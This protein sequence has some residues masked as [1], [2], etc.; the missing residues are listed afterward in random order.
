MWPCDDDQQVTFAV[1]VFTTSGIRWPPYLQMAN[2]LIA[3]FTCCTTGIAARRKQAPS[4]S[5][6]CTGDIARAASRY[7]FATVAFS[8]AYND[9]S[10]VINSSTPGTLNT[11]EMSSRGSQS[12]APVA[13]RGWS[14]APHSRCRTAAVVNSA[15]NAER[16]SSLSARHL[17]SASDNRSAP[18]QMRRAPLLAP[19]RSLPSWML[20]RHR[21]NYGAIEYQ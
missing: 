4:E 6:P 9:C 14:L 11:G 5:A 7:V 12:I 19:M 3:K 2:T 21:G 8:T 20:A 13:R 1:R 10:A 18:S 16:N 15:I 17:H